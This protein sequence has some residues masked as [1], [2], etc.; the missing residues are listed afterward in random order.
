MLL[1]DGAIAAVLV[2]GDPKMAGAAREAARFL[3]IAAGRAA[4]PS[5]APVRDHFRCWAIS[6]RSS[7]SARCPL[8]GVKQTQY[9]HSEFFAF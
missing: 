1:V 9:A 6:G 5:D 7:M 2:R 3:L 8:S 4:D